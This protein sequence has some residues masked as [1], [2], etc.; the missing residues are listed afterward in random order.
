MF[1]GSNCDRKS[2]LPGILKEP[3]ES[4]YL[5]TSCMY[6]VHCTRLP[7]QDE[8]VK[9]TRKSKDFPRYDLEKKEASL[10]F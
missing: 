8:T 10:Q 7:I 9:T 5:G 1:N 4:Y 6:T 3:L 2:Q